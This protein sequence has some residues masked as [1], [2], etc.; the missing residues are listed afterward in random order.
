VQ[1]AFP[2]F[3][4]NTLGGEK[5]LLTASDGQRLR[6]YCCGPTVYGPAHIGNFRTFLVQDVFRRTAEALGMPTM[7]VR[8][9]TDV[10]DKTIRSSLRE[11]RTLTEFTDY[12]TQAFHKDC[13]ALNLLAPHVEPSAIAHIPEQIAL[14]ETLIER[15]LAYQASDASV[16]FRISAFE[17]YGRLSGLR[18]DDRRGNAD[19]RLNQSD[20][21]AKEDFFDF[22]LWK[23][24]K[25][26]DGPNAWDSP[27]GRGRPGWHI[28]CSAMS[29]K[30]L[31]ES[32]DLH[33]GGVD[34]IFPHHEN[35]IAQSEGATGKPFVRHWFHVA[36]L[37]VD[38]AKMSKSL[39]N[40]YR[41]E[42][43]LSAGF[44]AEELRYALIAGHY[45]QPLNFTWESLKAAR[46]ALLRLR[47]F[48]Q[49]LDAAAAGS[50]VVS[51]S[52]FFDPVLEALADDLNVAK[53][54]GRLFSLVH[55]L[56]SGA[57][58]DKAAALPGFVRAMGALGLKLDVQDQAVEEAPAEVRALAQLRWESKNA[59]DWAR[60]DALRD[61]LLALG[62]AVKD[63][64][65]GFVLSPRT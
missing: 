52:G 29:M 16:Y 64:K 62:W 15:G 43:I 44:S 24:W 61:Q 2:F 40:L 42:D 10:D 13:A 39:G 21:Y 65:D 17:P 54:L 14:I 3:L 37:M 63:S 46:S 60:A 51:A 34:L 31:G 35:E 53:A 27:W 30:Y 7:H 4:T 45:R 19:G 50:P 33:S 18:K 5:E 28:E 9:L 26:E 49:G 47:R 32:F 38:G 6:M 41:L 20:E 22:A 11:G 12:W 25:P 1:T 58:L 55:E 23:A 56:E 8:N 59:K 48:K 57:E 36:H